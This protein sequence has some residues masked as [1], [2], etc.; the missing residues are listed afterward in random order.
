MTAN[1][2]VKMENVENDGTRVMEK[3]AENIEIL[4]TGV[5]ET[6]KSHGVGNAAVQQEQPRPLDVN[7]E[8][9]G[10]GV[11]HTA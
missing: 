6:S 9:K 5:R 10:E 7:Q 11:E 4:G 1:R 3:I 8:P 2:A